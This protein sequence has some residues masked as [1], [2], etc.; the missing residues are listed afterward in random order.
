MSN[1]Q[2]MR[3]GSAG[4]GMV[5]V[6]SKRVHGK[7]LIQCCNSHIKEQASDESVVM[8]ISGYPESWLG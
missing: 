3:D 1:L 5:V 4:N 8:G 2:H 6:V 7:N